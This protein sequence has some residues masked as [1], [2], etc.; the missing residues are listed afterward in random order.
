M[1]LSSKRKSFLSEILQSKNSLFAYLNSNCST[2]NDHTHTHTDQICVPTCEVCARV[3]TAAERVG[4]GKATDSTSGEE[5]SIRG[6]I[7]SGRIAGH[8]LCVRSPSCRYS[9]QNF[10]IAEIH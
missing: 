1:S 2:N 6:S 7:P 3:R 8:L 4:E 9:F 5:S 10:R